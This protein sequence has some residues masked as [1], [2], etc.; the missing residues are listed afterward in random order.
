MNKH[1]KTNLILVEKLA[2]E[3]GVHEEELANK[4]EDDITPFPFDFSYDKDK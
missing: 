2:H 1:R 4:E 3:G